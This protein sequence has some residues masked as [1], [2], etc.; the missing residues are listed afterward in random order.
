M[1]N[2]YLFLLYYIRY[3]YK[4]EQIIEYFSKL[5]FEKPSA[6]PSLIVLDDI[7]SFFDIAKVENVNILHHTHFNKYSILILLSLKELDCVR[8]AA[9]ICAHAQNVLTTLNAKLYLNFSLSQLLFPYI[10]Y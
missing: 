9:M 8:Q 7:I 2:S 3:F 1:L 10:N 6:I 4:Y 5:I